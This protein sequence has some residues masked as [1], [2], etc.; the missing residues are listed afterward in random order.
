MSVIARR[1]SGGEINFL[2]L[3]HR[4]KIGPCQLG[5]APLYG[6]EAAG[7]IDFSV[8]DEMQRA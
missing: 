8:Y 2:S 5:H 4:S 6:D 7:Y 1:Y 3:F